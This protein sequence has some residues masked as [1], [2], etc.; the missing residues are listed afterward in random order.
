MFVSTSAATIVKILSRPAAITRRALFPLPALPLFLTL[1]GG[2]EQLQPELHAQ[3]LIATKRRR[4][5]PYGVAGGR[6]LHLIAGTDAVSARQLAGDGDLKF[7]G[8]LGHR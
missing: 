6:P 7:A 4:G 3:R 2:I 5:D 1:G 8:D